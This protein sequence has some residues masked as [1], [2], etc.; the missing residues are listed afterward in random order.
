MPF[1]AVT[2]TV[3]PLAPT[4]SGS[5]GLATPEATKVPLTFTEAAGSAATGVRESAATENGTVS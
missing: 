4:A 1:G 5:A 3:N 2:S